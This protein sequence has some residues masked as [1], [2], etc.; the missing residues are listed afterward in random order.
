[1]DTDPSPRT[2]VESGC[3]GVLSHLSHYKG[4][5]KVRRWDALGSLVSRTMVSA[6]PNINLELDVAEISEF[7]GSGQ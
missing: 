7:A 2:I 5:G 6:N 4:C 3:S 1:M